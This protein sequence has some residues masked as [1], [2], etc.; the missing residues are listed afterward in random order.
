[1]VKITLN[2]LC[3]FLLSPIFFFSCE[4]PSPRFEKLLGTVC[5]VNLYG[6]GKDSYY[7]EI[8]DRLEEIH[9]EFSYSAL[10]SD[11][12]RIN[13]FA[14]REDVKLSDDVFTVLETA[15]KVSQLTEGAF[16]LSI[17]PLVSLWQINTPHPHLASE[18]EI[19]ERLPLVDYKN[20]LLNSS[21]KSVRLLKEGMK[22]DF[23]GI[24]KGFAADQ[25]VEICKKH[26]VKQ[27]VIDLGGNIYVY[28]KKKKGGKWTVGIKNPEYPDEAPLVKLELPQL[29]VVTS[30]SYERYFDEGEKRYH[31]IISPYTGV[32]IDN[33]LYSVSVIC[34]SSML[35][36]A[37]TTAFFVMGSEKAKAILPGL[38]EVF[39]SDMSL[40]LMKKNHSV[41]FSPDFPYK[42]AILYEN[43]IEEGGKSPK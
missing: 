34:Q 5:L 43:W 8:F 30:G 26:K 12:Y 21:D 41:E 32:P 28:G 23:G 39:K 3:L 38:K 16:D 18:N 35:A 37:F 1:M 29:S 27:A 7:D 13:A 15:L 6:D 36:D 9:N 20:I 40:V 17:E 25:I 42:K 24:V 10:D 33:E 4:A 2:R 14:F 19:K 11:I 22:L 31:H